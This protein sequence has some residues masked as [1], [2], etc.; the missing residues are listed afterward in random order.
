MNRT[1]ALTLSDISSLG[2]GDVTPGV[3]GVTLGVCGTLGVNGAIMAGVTVTLGAN[4]I[5]LAIDTGT[6][7][8]GI[9]GSSGRK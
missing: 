6:L 1:D 4:G 5:T 7:E 2:A 3:G 9:A 8:G